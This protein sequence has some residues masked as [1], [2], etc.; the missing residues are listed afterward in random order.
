MLDSG[1]EDGR[2]LWCRSEERAENRLRISAHRHGR[3]VRFLF[4]PTDAYLDQSPG[5]IADSEGVPGGCVYAVNREG[6]HSDGD[7]LAAIRGVRQ[8]LL[9]PPILLLLHRPWRH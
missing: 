6:T 1:N 7:L 3:R 4:W 2:D 9:Q 8:L 5:D